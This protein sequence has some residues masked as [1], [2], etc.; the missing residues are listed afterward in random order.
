MISLP[1]AFLKPEYDFCNI[2]EPEYILDLGANIG[3]F[4]IYMKNRFKNSKIIAVEP[5]A[6]NCQLLQNNLQPLGK[7]VSVVQAGIWSKKTLLKI[8]NPDA[9]KDGFICKE[10]EDEDIDNN[11]VEGVISAIDID[12]LLSDFNISQGILIKMDIEGAEKE[13]F[14]K[15]DNSGWLE[16]TDTLIIE[17]HN[18]IYPKLSE[19][20]LPLIEKRNFEW[21]KIGD[22][23]IC[24]RQF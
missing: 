14:D 24:S 4:S 1:G 3:I 19:S 6:S 12:T 17:I 2:R 20:I 21:T 22:N 13:V 8:L 18:R 5:E 16:K 9:E 11:H 7:D 23:Y 10:I 15:I